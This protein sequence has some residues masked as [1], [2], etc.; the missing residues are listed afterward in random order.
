MPSTRPRPARSAFTLIELLVVIAIIAILAGLLLP[1]LSQAKGKARTITCRN[2]QKQLA[3][4]WT[5]YQSDYQESLP[6][7]GVRGGTT[8]ADIMWVYGWDHSQPQSFTNHVALTD[9]RRSLF[10]PYL[11][12]K[13]VYKCPE[14]KSVVPQ[15]RGQPRVRSYSMN[16]YIA[17]IRGD[18]FTTAA[19]FAVF[20]KSTDFL[21][22][23]D[24]FLTMDVNPDTLCMPHFRV[25]MTGNNN[26]FHA[27]STLHSRSAVLAFADGHVESRK[28]RSLRPA[29]NIRHNFPAGADLTDLTWVRERTTYRR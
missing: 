15:F 9:P 23:A 29:R 22:P 27:P 13:A 4:T 8:A 25:L 5:L 17:P 10:A 11:K 6:N 16:A 2:N 20:R 26:W 28:W 3:I 7:N 19:A 18:N 1:A 12:S 14:D 21:R 24:I